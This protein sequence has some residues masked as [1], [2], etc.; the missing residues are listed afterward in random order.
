MQA[1][2]KR[3]NFMRAIGGGSLAALATLL[4]GRGAAAAASESPAADAP[5]SAKGYQLS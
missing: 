5:Q 2:N 1:N 4:I 3:R